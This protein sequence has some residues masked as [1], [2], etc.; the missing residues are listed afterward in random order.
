MENLLPI[1][2]QAMDPFGF[3]VKTLRAISSVLKI[4][5]TCMKK[6]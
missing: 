2:Q 1:P 5:A 3:L 4:K 6:P